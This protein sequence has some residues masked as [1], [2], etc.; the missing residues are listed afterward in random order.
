M[1]EKNSLLSQ[2]NAASCQASKQSLT[3][4][5]D[6]VRSRLRVL[7]RGESSRKRRWKTKKAKEAFLKNPYEAG[8]NILDPICTA[9]LECTQ[10]KLDLFKASN[11]SDKLCNNPLPPLEDL[12]PPPILTVDSKFY[13]FKYEDFLAIL[14]T[15]RN[16]SSPGLNMIPYKVYKNCPRIASFLF[17]IFQSG[18]KTNN[19]PISSYPGCSFC[20]C[21]HYEMNLRF[22]DQ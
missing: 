10:S 22:P 4:L 9:N 2:I 17:K 16:T 15:R 13:N 1:Q 5:L 12:P 19:I 14:N 7:R 6:I 11:L 18:F 3:S 21:F 20:T 8:K